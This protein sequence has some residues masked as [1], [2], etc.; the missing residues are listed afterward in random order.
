MRSNDELKSWLRWEPTV[1][2]LL[3]ILFVIIVIGAV[4]LRQRMDKYD[5]IFVVSALI[6]MPLWIYLMRVS[7]NYPLVWSEQEEEKKPSRPLIEKREQPKQVNQSFSERVDSVREKVNPGQSQS[8]NDDNSLLKILVKTMQETNIAYINEET[9]GI[10]AR[11]IGQ[12]GLTKQKIL[13]LA[14]R[15]FHNRFEY[16]GETCYTPFTE[17][18]VSK[19]MRG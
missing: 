10:L 7:I 11:L 17:E 2:L 19:N 3:I 8:K 15:N 18:V 12:S 16:D 4:W 14:K 13:D 1:A 5:H 6:G 9:S